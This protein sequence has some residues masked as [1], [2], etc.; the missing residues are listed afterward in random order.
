[1][2]PGQRPQGGLLG[3]HRLGPRAP[4]R[5]RRRGGGRAI[6]NI[7]ARVAELRRR[8]A[9][10]LMGLMTSDD[11]PAY[12]TAIRHAYGETVTPPRT[13]RR[14]RA[15]SPYKVAPAG[16]TYATVSK[17]REKGRVVEIGTRIVF[18]TVTAVLL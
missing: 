15:R 18:G 3:P 12:E 8:T 4:A 17:R 13:G 9:G 14:G 11:Y 1:R 5:R 2:Q 7:R 6:E 10:R 16:L